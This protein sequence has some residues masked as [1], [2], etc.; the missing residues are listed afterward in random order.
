MFTLDFKKV[1]RYKYKI[2]NTNDLLKGEDIRIIES[3]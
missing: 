3:E 1:V 2:I